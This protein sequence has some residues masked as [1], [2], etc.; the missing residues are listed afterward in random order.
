MWQPALDSDDNLTFA[1]QIAP[2]VQAAF[3]GMDTLAQESGICTEADV[4]AFLAQHHLKP[5]PNIPIL[6]A[7]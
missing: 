5:E 7:T 2:M 1:T 6:V 3:E 4:H